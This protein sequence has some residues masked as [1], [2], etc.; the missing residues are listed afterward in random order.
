MTGTESDALIR[1]ALDALLSGDCARCAEICSGGTADGRLPALRGLSLLDARGASDPERALDEASP[2]IAE[3]V[4]SGNREFVV[5]AMMGF[6][7]T[8]RR[9]NP[10][11]DY[12]DIVV[13]GEYLGRTR[14][15]VAG[16]YFYLKVREMRDA[17]VPGSPLPEDVDLRSVARIYLE[18]A[19]I[20]F[21]DYDAA[22]KDCL[23]DPT[24][25]NAGRAREALDNIDLLIR[26][27]VFHLSETSSMF[28]TS[29]RQWVNK[30]AFRCARNGD[31]VTYGREDPAFSASLAR[32]RK[33]ADGILSD[34]ALTALQERRNARHAEDV[35]WWVDWGREN[36]QK[37]NYQLE[38]CDPFDLT[39]RHYLTNLINVT[40]DWLMSLERDQ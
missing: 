7:D 10:F 29:Y 22:C 15:M 5:E 3:S 2:L 20:T 26:Y 35:K 14:E 28:P 9:T 40:S 8:L 39:Q 33:D 32:L 31:Y 36:L 11:N 12:E 21:T 25:E 16:N 19:D 13:D 23:N 27:G 4:T 37:L 34:P 18:L 17:L 24:E 6:A 30:L 38:T 1:R